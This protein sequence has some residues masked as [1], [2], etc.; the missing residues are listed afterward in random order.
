MTTYSIVEYEAYV[1]ATGEP[2]VRPDGTTVGPTCYAVAAEEAFCEETYRL[3][4]RVDDVA[5]PTSEALFRAL[6][7][8]RCAVRFVRAT[9]PT[10]RRAA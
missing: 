1:V 8:T 7:E 4:E 9:P 2:V 3:Q 10:V 5:F 6:A